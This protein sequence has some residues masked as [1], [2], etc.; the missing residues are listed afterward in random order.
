MSSETESAGTAS[1]EETTDMQ[2]CGTLQSKKDI[3]NSVSPQG[4]RRTGEGR[5]LAGG[6]IVKFVSDSRGPD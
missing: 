5:G 6:Q 1:E 3:R 2:L 4:C